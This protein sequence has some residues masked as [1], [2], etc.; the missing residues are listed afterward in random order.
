MD[1]IT[2]G[3]KDKKSNEQRIHINYKFSGNII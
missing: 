1:S 2:V 3:E